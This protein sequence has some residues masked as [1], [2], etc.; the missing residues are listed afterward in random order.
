ML[1][2]NTG[3]ME[4]LLGDNIGGSVLVKVMDSLLWQQDAGSG[5]SLRQ[6]RRKGSPEKGTAGLKA[7]L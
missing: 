7:K 4:N 3:K 6:E 5:G 2:K 1:S